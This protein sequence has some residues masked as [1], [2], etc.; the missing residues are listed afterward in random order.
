MEI[1]KQELHDPYVRDAAAEA[2]EGRNDIPTETIKQWM[3]SADKH[4]RRA[5]M[6]ACKGRQEDVPL[7]IIKKG[8]RDNNLNVCRVAAEACEGRSDISI[9]TIR[10]WIE[11]TGWHFR[12]AAMCACKG[13][14]DI[15]PEISEQVALLHDFGAKTLIAKKE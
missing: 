8:L 14:Q 3:K 15:P 11:S 9:E 2:C 4:I 7:K 1:V 5:A 6:Y 12:Y 13:R 10:D